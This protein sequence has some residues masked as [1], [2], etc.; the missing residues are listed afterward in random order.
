M[1]LFPVQ[2]EG[3]FCGVTPQ[4][5][6]Q[7]LLVIWGV[8][9]SSKGDFS[10]VKRRWGRIPSCKPAREGRSLGGQLSICGQDILI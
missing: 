5:V 7:E 8:E 4:S 3:E 10:L 9:S 2:K 1:W 6:C